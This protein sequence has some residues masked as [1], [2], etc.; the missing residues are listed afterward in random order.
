MYQAM[1]LDI[2][3]VDDNLVN[4]KVGKRILAM[5]GYANVASATDGRMAIEAAEKHHFD[6]ILMDLQ[7]PILDGFTAHERIKASPLAGYP[8]VVALTANA[9][10]VSASR[11]SGLPELISLQDTRQRCKLA[12]FFDYL[13]KPLVIPLLEKTIAAAFVYRQKDLDS[14]LATLRL[15]A[16]S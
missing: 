15:E 16:A 8:C 7:M 6:L 4:L 5:F 10:L 13:S 14:R 11:P 2:L 1:P 3:L 9:D 12:G